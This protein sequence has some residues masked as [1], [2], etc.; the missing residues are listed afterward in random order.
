MFKFLFFI[1][2]LFTFAFS[3][4]ES[5]QKVAPVYKVLNLRNTNNGLAADL[6]LSSGAGPY[7]DDIK[8]LSLQIFFETLN[9]VR[10]KITDK[11]EERWEGKINS[12]IKKT[13]PANM[14]KSKTPERSPSVLNYKV[15]VLD[16]FA[17]V[18][19]RKFNNEII[20]DSRNSPFV[21]SKYYLEIGTNLIDENPNIY[22]LGERVHNFRLDPKDKTYVMFNKDAFTVEMKNLYG[23]HP[24]YV[25]KRG[26]AETTHA[27]GVFFSNTNAMEVNIKSSKLT[28]RTIGGILNFYVFAGPLPQDVVKQYH[29]VIG[30]PVMIPYWSL[31]FHHTR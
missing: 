4:Q 18:I 3:S 16:P 23:T 31:G 25:Q 17:I 11:N 13:V 28:Y 8:S 26:L 27:H 14:I 30:K 9:R 2:L 20:F 15:E 12:K 5:I 10:V 22:G 6:T 1:C 21:Y 24:F 19:T 7:G 29:E